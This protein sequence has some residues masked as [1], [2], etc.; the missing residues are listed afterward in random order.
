MLKK[1]E[2]THCGPFV[3]CVT[4]GNK[5]AS[6][7]LVL[8][9]IQHVYFSALLTYTLMWIRRINSNSFI[10]KVVDSI[11]THMYMAEKTQVSQEDS[12]RRVL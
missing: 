1:L 2:C 10:Y 11:N 7:F 4:Y 8:P 6:L 9:K 3:R 12:H 5:W